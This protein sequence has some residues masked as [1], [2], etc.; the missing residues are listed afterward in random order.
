[1]QASN[2][3][4]TTLSSVSLSYDQIA[5]LPV[6]TNDTVSALVVSGLNYT[7]VSAVI[8]FSQYGS[9]TQVTFTGAKGNETVVLKLAEASNQT[10][11]GGA[12]DDRLI[13]VADGGSIGAFTGSISLNGETG[14]DTLP[15]SYTHLTLPTNRDV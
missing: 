11:T 14:T 10:F 7:G 6:G 1:M 3:G 15:V 2:E 12:G 4:T 8:D 13:I 5:A 9:G